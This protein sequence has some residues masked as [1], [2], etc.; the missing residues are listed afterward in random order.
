MGYFLSIITRVPF[1]GTEQSLGWGSGKSKWLR[2]LIYQRARLCIAASTAVANEF[3]MIGMGNTKIIPNGVDLEKFRPPGE[4]FHKETDRGDEALPI[5]DEFFILCVGRLEKV[6]GHQYLI[7]AFSKI[8]KE[9][10]R[11]KLIL[12]GDGSERRNFEKQAE[13]LGVK[14][15]VRFAGEIRHDELPHYYH[16]ADVF[17]MPS[18]SEGFGITAIEAMACGVAVIA[19]RVGGLLDIIA[20]GKGGILVEAG[21]SR[22]IARAVL[23]L[24]NNPQ[25]TRLLKGQGIER[26]QEYSWDRVA[27]RVTALYKNFI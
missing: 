2:R 19:T 14:D 18:L 8:I 15:S 7:D 17:V 26:A 10:P 24:S 1:I 9:I 25:K 6:K 21:D 4:I 13:E 11:A 16:Q 5:R 27:S 12:V 22:A 20:D 3:G 23:F